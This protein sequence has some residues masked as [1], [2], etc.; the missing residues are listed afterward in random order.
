MASM[1]DGRDHDDVRLEVADQHDLP[2]GHAAGDR[3]DGAAERLGAVVRAE[4]AG[5]Q[6]VAVGDMDDVA[7]PAAG[8]AD[9]SGPSAAAQVS[10]SRGV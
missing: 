3:D 7:G 9:A 5:E 8:G 10:M 2:L 1:Y 4:A 6:A